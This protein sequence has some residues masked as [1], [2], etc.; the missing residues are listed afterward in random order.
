MEGNAEVST[1]HTMLKP[2]GRIGYGIFCGFGRCR[3][4]EYGLNSLQLVKM[5]DFSLRVNIHARIVGFLLSNI[6]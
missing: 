2:E 1:H 5:L 4:S 6:Q 3:A